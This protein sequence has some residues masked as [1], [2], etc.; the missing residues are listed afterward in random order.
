M[1]AGRMLSP[2]SPLSILGKDFLQGLPV[3][4][5]LSPTPLCPVAFFRSLQ[6]FFNQRVGPYQD[7]VDVPPG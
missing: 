1:S 6:D 5:L 3:P 7:L 2:A 4:K